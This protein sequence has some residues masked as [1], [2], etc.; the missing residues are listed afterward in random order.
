MLT[1]V[2]A[3]LV[4]PQTVDRPLQRPDFARRDGVAMPTL[5]RDDALCPPPIVRADQ[6]VSATD[7]LAFR[8]DGEAVGHYLL[9]ER[10]VNGCSRPLVVNH[11]IRG[12]NALGRE[13][14]NVRPLP[15]PFD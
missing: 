6:P 12:S 2:L 10:R 15:Q 8:S 1:L 13:L 3:L 14:G 4:S 9:L 5:G 11:R 7:D